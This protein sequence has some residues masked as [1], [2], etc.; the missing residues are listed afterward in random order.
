LKWRVPSLHP[1]LAAALALGGCESVGPVALQ[2]DRL[3]Y[4]EALA[5]SGKR[6]SL[7]N[8]VRLKHGDVPAFVS[9][10]TI[11]GAY[12]VRGELEVLGG[13]IEALGFEN[14]VGARALVLGA[15][16]PTVTYSPLR[17]G[18]LASYLLQPIRPAELLSVVESSTRVELALLLG[19][20]GFHGVTNDVVPCTAA[21]PERSRFAQ[22][23]RLISFLQG[24]GGFGL[25]WREEAQGE[26]RLHLVF[27]TPP[28]NPRTVE[29]VDELKALLDLPRDRD[30]FAVTYGRP[31]RP[32]EIAIL[33]R[34]V[35]QMLTLVG[36]R[37]AH[38]RT[39][40]ARAAC[41]GAPRLIDLRFG[42][43]PPADAYAAVP[44]EGRWWWIAE[45]DAASKAA[46]TF[47]QVLMALALTGG[48]D[49][50]LLLTVPTGGG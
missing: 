10:S 12:T 4:V 7:L 11:V 33:S 3:D 40:A 50:S 48:G 38:A 8:V 39:D 14:D 46:F 6:E 36:A 13:V 23:V 15:D 37:P 44:Y 41:L 18:D 24:R 43:R 30:T 20:A 42:P 25:M 47:L 21:A 27:N 35:L 31:T 5:E 19:V 16:R 34:T 28:E 2:R 1:A 49:E 17:G 22:V 45:D 26:R 9:V 29:A 32:D